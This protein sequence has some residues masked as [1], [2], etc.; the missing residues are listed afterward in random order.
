MLSEQNSHN[1]LETGWFVQ[2]FQ[3]LCTSSEFSFFP[4][5]AFTPDFFSVF[6]MLLLII[7]CKSQPKHIKQNPRDLTLLP[8]LLVLSGRF[9]IDPAASTEEVT[10]SFCIYWM[11]N[12][13]SLLPPQPF[14]EDKGQETG[15]RW[16]WRSCP[17]C[18]VR[19]E[20]NLHQRL[21]AVVQNA[22]SWAWDEM[23]TC[24]FSFTACGSLL[25]V[26][27]F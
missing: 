25:P 19:Q 15:V 13:C 23:E 9:Y 6:S 4:F 12:T 11:E 14:H 26:W 2:N 5:L 27:G 7:M 8:L 10:F 18:W 22:E 24:K 16:E 17:I 21:S 1:N 20:K 3:P